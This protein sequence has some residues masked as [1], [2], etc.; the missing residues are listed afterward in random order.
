MASPEGFACLTLCQ[1]VG[2]GERAPLVAPPMAALLHRRVASPP[3]VH[4]MCTVARFSPRGNVLAYVPPA[5]WT[6]A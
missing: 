4:A 1:N 6:V 2:V 3:H 5:A